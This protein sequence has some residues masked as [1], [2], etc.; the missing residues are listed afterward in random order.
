MKSSLVLILALIIFS[1]VMLNDQSCTLAQSSNEGSRKEQIDNNARLRELMNELQ[2][3]VIT[4]RKER[5]AYY[6][7]KQE[8][9]QE[10][11]DLRIQIQSLRETHEDLVSEVE[12]IENEM[13]T[14]NNEESKFKSS[15]LSYQNKEDELSNY[16]ISHVRLLREQVNNGIPFRLEERTAKLDTISNGIGAQKPMDIAEACNQLWSFCKE[17]LR[18]AVTS[19]IYRD[20][21]RLADGREPHAEFVRVGR[22]ILAFMTEDGADW[23]IWLEQKDDSPKGATTGWVKDSSSVSS[24]TIEK[25]IK[26]LMR[27]HPPEIINFPISF[28]Q[29]RINQG[30]E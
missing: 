25:S 2:N 20:N 13:D 7:R 17:E 23:G 8:K 16:V 15:I 29:V 21:I 11:Q 28:S 19:E 12:D 1:A 6:S 26:I 10:V 9:D 3:T 27:Q 22:V 14:L 18:L 4:L 30:F 24:H 5:Q